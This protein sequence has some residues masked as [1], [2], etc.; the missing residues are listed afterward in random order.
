VA[1]DRTTPGATLLTAARLAPFDPGAGIAIGAASPDFDDADWLEIAIPGDVHRTLIDAGEI[2]DPFWDQQE[3]DC[4]WMED[5]EWWYRLPLDVPPGNILAATERWQLVFHGLDTYATIYLDGEAIGSS[6]NMFHDTVIDI[7]GRVAPGGSYALALLF[8]PPL[9]VTKGRPRGEWGA[10]PERTVMRKAQFGYGWDWGPRLP[11]I[12]A[13]RPIELRRVDRA[14][15]LGVGFATVDLTPDRDQAVVCVRVEAER[16]AGDDPLRARVRLTEPGTG[17]AWET[18]FD[19]PE[20]SA[21]HADGRAYL[22]IPKPWLWWTHDLGQPFLHDLE[23]ELLAGEDVVARD[24]R[25]VGVRTLQLDQSVDTAEPGTR[26]FRFVLNGVPIFAKGAD[27][28]PADSFVGAIEDTRYARWLHAARDANMTMLRVWGGGIY[29]AD[30]FYYLCDRMGILVWQDFM[31]ACAAYPEGDPA[32]VREVDLEARYQVRRLRSHPSLAIWVGNNENQWLND[33][34]HW[35]VPF[36]ERPPYGERYYNEILP[37]AVRERDGQT[38]YWP[39][40]PYGGNDYNSMEEGNR[41]NWD[42]WHGQS[43]RRFG[44]Q[45]TQVITPEMVSYRRYAEDL[46]RFC[47]EFGLHASPVLSTLR[48]AVPEDEL[49]HHSP[50]MDWHNKDTPKNKGDMLMESVTGVP[51]TLADYIDFSQIAQAEGLKFGIEHFRRR[52]PHCSGTLVW[53]M[54]DCWPVLSWSVMDYYGVGKAGY[55]YLKRVYAPVLASFKEAEDRVELWITNDTLARVE[56]EVNVTLGTFAGETLA[57][58]PLVVDLPPNSSQRVHAFSAD[59]AG[60]NRY[61]WVA[62]GSGRFPDNRHFFVAFKDLDREPA[63][64][65]VEMRQSGEG[66]VAVT[67]TA[68]PDGYCWFVH[69]ERPQPTTWYS[70]NYVD[71]APGESKTITVRDTATPV[72]PDEITVGWR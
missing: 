5:R 35:N 42:A 18:T 58:W 19:L 41:H 28:I 2:P 57:T 40:S 60:N 6:Q 27:W 52:K 24:I 39:G 46:T 64:P 34:K 69:L 4:A 59:V 50:A 29:E 1:T 48:R 30:I 23:T 71:L 72:N 31:F 70:D 15:I 47:S 51:E 67:L 22:T 44:E 25:R 43:P 54:N 66:E 32:F 56:D 53:Q 16:V 12:G 3:R 11:T 7:T 17:R 49:Y 61:L 33:G 10:N 8:H 55:Y 26:F 38:A 62:S 9:L 14:T 45:P 13:W 36:A 65:V 68:P 63:E 37:D 20:T 21:G